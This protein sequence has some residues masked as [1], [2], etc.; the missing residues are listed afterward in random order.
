MLEHFWRHSNP[1]FEKW[2]N[3]KKWP[4]SPR[5][6][7]KILQIN[8][9]YSLLD[10]KRDQKCLIRVPLLNFPEM[11]P[12]DI[13]SQFYQMVTMGTLTITKIFDFSFHYIFPSSMN[14]QSFV[15]IK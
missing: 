1:K 10:L 12:P 3:T 8:S 2:K 7:R 11:R 15:A 9:W 14:V 5:Q 13:F 6:A 4:R